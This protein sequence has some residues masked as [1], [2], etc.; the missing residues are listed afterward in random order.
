MDK[1]PETYQM[2]DELIANGIEFETLLL[3]DLDDGIIHVYLGSREKVSLLMEIMSQLP[4]ETSWIGESSI[5]QRNDQVVKEI[6][7]ISRLG[8]T[9]FFMLGQAIIRPDAKDETI[10]RFEAFTSKI[11]NLLVSSREKS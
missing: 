7:L 3:G 5:F 9:D 2:I 1:L 6:L 11:L 8:T 4:I 10:R